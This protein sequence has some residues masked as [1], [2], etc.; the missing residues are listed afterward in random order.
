MWFLCAAH[1]GLFNAASLGWDFIFAKTGIIFP[2]YRY[3]KRKDVACMLTQIVLYTNT[4]E[5]YSEVILVFL[6]NFKP[7]P[8][9]RP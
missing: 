7:N 9:W 4:V 3:A 5:K 8:L 1:I 6:L 2:K